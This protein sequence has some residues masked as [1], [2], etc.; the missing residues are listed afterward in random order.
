MVDPEFV[1]SSQNSTRRLGFRAD[2]AARRNI[3]LTCLGVQSRPS[4]ALATSKRAAAVELAIPL[5]VD[6]SLDYYDDDLGSDTVGAMSAGFALATSAFAL[7][8]VVVQRDHA[9]QSFRTSDLAAGDSTVLTMTGT[10][11]VNF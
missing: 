8:H 10:V 1:T 5:E 6:L 4:F 3:S 11:A 2:L 9:R 7:R